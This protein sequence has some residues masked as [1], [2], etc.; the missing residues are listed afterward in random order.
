MTTSAQPEPDTFDRTLEELRAAT[1]RLV[2]TARAATPDELGAASPLPGWSRAHVLS[3]VAQNALGLRNLATW[4]RTGVRTPMYA[5]QEQRDADID[6]GARQDA[7]ALVRQV[8]DTAADL[9]ADLTALP[10]EALAGTV[11]MRG[12]LRVPGSAL[13]WL[14]LREIEVHHVDLDL[15]Y[16]I[17]DWD[18]AFARRA[19]EGLVDVWRSRDLLPPVRITATDTDLDTVSGSGA[20][21]V[22]GTTAHLL[23]WLLGRPGADVRLQGPAVD[24]PAL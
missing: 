8:V 3:H 23:G 10:P 17:A 5:G 18:A 12:G 15:G 9:D 6:T 19:V 7:A 1:A 13:A 4:A 21:S 22:R 11:E 16:G 20:T 2:A 14:R 24:L